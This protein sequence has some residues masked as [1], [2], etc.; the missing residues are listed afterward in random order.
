[1]TTWK[2]FTLEAV[3]TALFTPEVSA[4]VSARAVAAVLPKYRERYD[5]AMQALPL[6]ADVPAEIPRVVLQSS[7]GSWRLAMGQ[8]RIDSFWN[9]RGTTLHHD[10]AEIVADCVAVFELYVREMGAPVGQVALLVWRIC[11][12]ENPAEA[13]I[14]RFCNESSQ[15]E[16]FNRSATFEIH[17]HKVYT[18]GQGITYPINSWV[19]CKSATMA[20][21]VGN[22]PVILVEQDL[23]N[24]AQNRSPRRISIEEMRSFFE[25]ALLEADAIFRKYFPEQE[26]P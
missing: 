23:N 11:P 14:H 10:L 25:T 7:D 1:M 15:K 26:T 8:A 17:N 19:R 16:P 9:N 20:A 6:P 2:D 13:I 3:Q 5:G 22:R 12:V 24:L 4:F 18:P 21:A